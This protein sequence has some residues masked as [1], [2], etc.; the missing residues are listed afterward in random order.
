MHSFTCLDVKNPNNENY[1]SKRH[2]VLWSVFRTQFLSRT[3]HLGLAVGMVEVKISLAWHLRH[4]L[5][6]L[7]LKKKVSYKEFF[8]FFQYFSLQI[9][10]EFPCSKF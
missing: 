6:G 9:S 2:I 7:S 10:M 3:V 8:Y 4:V 1:N 5:K